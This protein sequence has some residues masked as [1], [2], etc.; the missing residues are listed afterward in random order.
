MKLI[1]I[2][3]D[4][5]VFSEELLHGEMFIVNMDTFFPKH[6]SMPETGIVV[7]IPEGVFKTQKHMVDSVRE[8]IKAYK[9]QP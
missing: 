3:D 4:V 5:K 6:P 2:V 8:A 1:T 7:L 9:Q